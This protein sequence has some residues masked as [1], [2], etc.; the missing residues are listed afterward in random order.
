MCVKCVRAERERVREMYRRILV[1]MLLVIFFSLMAYDL[2]GFDDP[3]DTNV[4]ALAPEVADSLYHNED[5]Y[6]VENRPTYF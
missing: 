3:T 6:P 1:G 5:S 4:E 2:L